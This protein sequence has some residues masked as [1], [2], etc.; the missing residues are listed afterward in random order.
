MADKA[1]CPHCNAAMEGRWERLTTGLVNTLVKFR[2]AVV[3]AG[4]N[5]VNPSRISSLTHGEKANFQKLRFH[6]LVAKVEKDG[7][8]IHGQWLLTRR[9]GLFLRGD[10]S[11]PKAVFVFRNRVEKHDIEYINIVDLLREG[12]PRFDGVYDFDYQ[13]MPGSEK[14][15]ELF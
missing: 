14:Q 7:E 2:Q 4:K 1:R 10:E 8:H 13:A 3:D 15:G 9:G 5:S 12:P 6:G 11:V